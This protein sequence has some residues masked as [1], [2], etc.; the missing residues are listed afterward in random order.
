VRQGD[1]YTTDLST[2]TIIFVYLGATL[3]ELFERLDSLFEAGTL[4]VVVSYKFKL[5][6]FEHP[7]TLDAENE[8]YTYTK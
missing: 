7:Y 8:M 1:I 6:G 4:R 3:P 5:I 2:A